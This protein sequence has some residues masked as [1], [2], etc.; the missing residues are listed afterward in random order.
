V[1]V[2]KQA[3]EGNLPHTVTPGLH[4]CHYPPQHVCLI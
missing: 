3:V 1:K 2:E 4:V